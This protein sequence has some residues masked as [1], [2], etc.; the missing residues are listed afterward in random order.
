MKNRVKSSIAPQN[1]G[2]DFS[3]LLLSPAC[4]GIRRKKQEEISTEPATTGKAA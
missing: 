1:L 2:V 3:N 4:K